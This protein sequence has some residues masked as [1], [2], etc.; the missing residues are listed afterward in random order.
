M[1]TLDTRAL[2]MRDQ[3]DSWRDCVSPCSPPLPKCVCRVWA[4]HGS[5][6]PRVKARTFIFLETLLQ[7]VLVVLVPRGSTSQNNSSSTFATSC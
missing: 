2:N 3:G 4:L 6:I 5:S 7:A 1:K